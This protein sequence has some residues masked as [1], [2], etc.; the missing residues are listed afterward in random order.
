MAEL[1]T[2]LAS[3]G[4][5]KGDRVVVYMP[6]VPETLVAMLA[7]ARLGAIHS[8]VFGG[9]GAPE[10]AARID[11][12]TPTA[13]LTASCGVE[14]GGRLV[15]YLPLLDAALMHADHTPS[16]VLV[17]DRTDAAHRAVGA[18]AA[19]D[20]ALQLGALAPSLGAEDWGDAV[21]PLASVPLSQLQ[22][23]VPVPSSHPL[24]ILYTSGTTGAPKGVVR[25]SGGYAATLCWTM[26]HFFRVEPGEA[27]LCASDLGW[28]V[29]HSYIAYAPLLSGC[30]TVVYEGKPV[31]AP[32]ASA[33]WRAVDRWR[34]VG[35]FAAPTALR[36]IRADDPT[37][38][39]VTQHDL[40]SLRALFVAGERCASPAAAPPAKNTSPRPPRSPRRTTR[41]RR[42]PRP[43]LCLSGPG[44]SYFHQPPALSHAP[45]LAAAPHPQVRPTHCGVD[46]RRARRPRHRPLVAD[47]DGLAH[48]R[49]SRP[50]HRIG[51]GV[52][53]LL[54]AAVPPAASP[55]PRPPPPP[56]SYVP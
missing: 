39:G 28:V 32:D 53:H 35:L 36:A 56:L 3:R 25:D 54:S 33:L 44:L 16:T 52:R 30:T 20:S 15:K 8:V 18:T 26:R 23:C 47:R 42:L 29:G 14:T 40:S 34:A 41:R 11:D 50:S 27:W 9:F 17:L 45:Y 7:C 1:A 10:L 38:Q 51:R 19:S 2:A 4:V 48:L 22:P 13:V 12:A 5:G 49:L 43:L 24:Y 6:M 46:W 31:G 55:P 37:A 21:A